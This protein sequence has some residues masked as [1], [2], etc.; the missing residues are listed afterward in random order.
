MRLW[1]ALALAGCVGDVGTAGP[2]SGSNEVIDAAVDAPPKLM[3]PD[4][5]PGMGTNLPCENTIANPTIDGRHNTGQSCFQSCHNH[6]FTLAG[7]LY[8]NSTGNTGFKGATVTVTDNNGAVKKPV[9]AANGNFYTKDPV[10]FPVLVI[11]SACPSAVKMIHST[12]NGDCNKAGCHN[13]GPYQMH[14][15]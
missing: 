1:F 7:T 15:P 12:T 2:G 4:A 9:V 13:G 14:L 5:A 10:A 6:G 11:A 3:W 8:T